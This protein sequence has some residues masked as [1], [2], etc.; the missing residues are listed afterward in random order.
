MML[1]KITQAV[2]KFHV[3]SSESR[4]YLSRYYFISISVTI[5]KYYIRSRF[6]DQFLLIGHEKFCIRDARKS[7]YMA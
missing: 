7:I 2:K 5:A 3:L 6:V 4:Q 1:L